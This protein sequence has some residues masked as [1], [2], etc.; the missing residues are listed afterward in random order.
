MKWAGAALIAFVCACGTPASPQAHAASA[1]TSPAAVSSPSPTPTS[2]PT[3]IPAVKLGFSCR[4]PITLGAG[5]GPQGS[6]IDFPSGRVTNDPRSPKPDSLVRP[7]RELHGYYAALYF[8]RAYK[9]WLPVGREAVSLDGAH[10]AYTDRPIL[11]QPD[12][13]ARATLHVV[14]VKTGVDVTFDGGDWSNPYAVLDYAAEGIYLIT[15]TGSYFGLWLMDPITGGVTRVAD[16]PNVQ[17]RADRN[18]IWVGSVNPSDP[19]PIAGVAPDQLDRVSLVDGSRVTWFYRPGNSVHFVGQDVAGHPI[20][21]A[22]PVNGAGY[23]LALGPGINRSIFVFGDKR[24]ALSDAIADRHG[25]WFG[26]I[27][28]IYLYTEDRG[29][30]KVSNQPGYPANGC[31]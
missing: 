1:S 26:S 30:V 3:P 17:G 20:I 22:G 18:H 15:D 6:F 25:I 14:A 4:L 8:D 24:P 28:G 21:L 9:R 19:N 27:D 23:L 13:L 5:P 16:L 2:S 10:Y 29:L 12:P 31:I 11:A 7:G